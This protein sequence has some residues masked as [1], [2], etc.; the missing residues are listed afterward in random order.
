MSIS[1]SRADVTLENWRL[2]PFSRFSFQNVSEFVPT[3]TIVEP[4]EPE[5]ASPGIGALAEM[6]LSDTGGGEISAIGHLERSYGDHFVVMRDGE[7]IAEWVA[8]HAD[9]RKPHVVFSISKSVTGLL[10]GIAAGEGKL[11]PEAK[12][13][14]YVPSMA[15]SAY[16]NARVRDLLDMTVDLD[17]DEAYLDAGGAF[18][19]YRRAM[20][21]NPERGDSPP[22]TME[23]FLATL[24]TRGGGHGERFYYASPDTDLLGIVVERATGTRYHAYLAE[25][26]WRPMGARGAAYVTVER[27]GSARAAGGVCVTTRDLARMGQLVLDGGRNRSGEKVVPVEWLRDLHANGDRQAWIDGNFADMFANGRYRSC[28]YDVGDGRGSFCGVGIH[29]QWLWADPQSRVVLAKTS[30][31][32]DPSDD[33]ATAVEIS[34]LGQIARAYQAR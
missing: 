9:P 2:H 17:F 6:T 16:A 14:T 11:D 23:Q 8:G 19:R 21:W 34:M 7:I 1:F 24:A 12:V 31:R 27:V 26:L 4:G 29:G 13:P 22:E 20:L 25:K 10:A 28:W 3:A 15:G 32:P 5:P 30:S 18:D 33:A